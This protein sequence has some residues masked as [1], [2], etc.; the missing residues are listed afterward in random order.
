MLSLN[1]RQLSLFLLFLILAG[2]L[3][4]GKSAQSSP[5]PTPTE[6][7]EITGE[8]PV[9]SGLTGMRFVPSFRQVAPLSHLLMVTENEL[10]QPYFARID[11]ASG[12][13]VLAPAGPRPG[14]IHDSFAESTSDASY[15][16]A[17]LLPATG[18]NN[19]LEG[20]ID[21]AV[22]K[23]GQW[24]VEEAP[25]RWVFGEAKGLTTLDGTPFVLV[26][27]LQGLELWRYAGNQWTSEA[28]PGASAHPIA[29]F[30]MAANSTALFV[31]GYDAQEHI[32]MWT[33]QR[34][35]DW[36]QDVLQDNVTIL[37]GGFF[38]L[39][40]PYDGPPIASWWYFGALLSNDSRGSQRTYVAAPS[41]EGW[42]VST[43]GEEG[44][45]TEAVAAMRAGAFLHASEIW[46]L[47]DGSWNPCELAP[48]F[49]A[50]R[51]QFATD[52]QQTLFAY[53]ADDLVTIR[54]NLLS[55][56]SENCA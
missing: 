32:S 26:K 55:L 37:N 22:Y 21:F 34:G 12:E 41:A 27:R 48:E 43:V 2:C 51:W 17:N 35:G 9:P 45:L 1:K 44:N 23:Q 7:T 50:R 3:D 36:G 8:S 30:A 31:V 20:W 16:I 33:R 5:S 13:W 14:G 46:R 54:W 28:V 18:G 42:K 53:L 15:V 52:G 49:S 40:A 11:L 29:D 6:T 19:M 4:S 56:S 25:P 47:K 38:F 24:S 39:S 10:N